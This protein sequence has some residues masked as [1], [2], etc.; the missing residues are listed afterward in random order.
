MSEVKEETQEEQVDPKMEEATRWYYS[1]IMRQLMESER[2]QNWFQCNYEIHKN[3]DM[4]A[5]RIDI[6]V[7]ELPPEL[8]QQRMMENMAAAAQDES[9][10]VTATPEQLNKELSKA[11]KRRKRKGNK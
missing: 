10:I 6:V 8:V 7:L 3:V 9:P 11:N 1:E 5:K 2:F 4:E